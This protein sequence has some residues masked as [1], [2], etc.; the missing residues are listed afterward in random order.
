MPRVL[1]NARSCHP[2]LLQA[3]AQVRKSHMH[4][5]TGS[6]LCHW[7]LYTLCWC[8]RAFGLDKQWLAHPPHCSEN[9]GLAGLAFQ[10]DED[11]A[12]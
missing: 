11:D 2:A 6:V 12:C 9:Q 4:M 5:E 1:P 8:Q 7:A 10:M 3:S